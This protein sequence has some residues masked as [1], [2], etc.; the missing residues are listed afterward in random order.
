MARFLNFETV[1]IP[2]F[3]IIFSFPNSYYSQLQIALSPGS[4]KIQ[5]GITDS[6]YTI[7]S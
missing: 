7:H 4:F 5:V 1:Q 3:H 2:H 6:L